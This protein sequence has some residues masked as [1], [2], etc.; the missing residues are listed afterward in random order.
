MTALEYMKKYGAFEIKHE[1]YTP[2]E[3][4]VDQS[5][6]DGL[7]DMQGRVAAGGKVVAVLGG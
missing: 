6:I 3:N 5:S 4:V 1:N 7:T 2:Y